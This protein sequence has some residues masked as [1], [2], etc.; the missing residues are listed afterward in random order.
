MDGANGLEI[1]TGLGSEPR[2]VDLMGGPEAIDGVDGDAFWRGLLE[3]ISRRN[4]SH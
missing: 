3:G 1:P 2:F 4:F